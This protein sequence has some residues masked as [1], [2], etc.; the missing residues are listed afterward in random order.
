[1]K[2]KSRTKHLKKLGPKS[3]GRKHLV[4]S[5]HIYDVLNEKSKKKIGK[6]ICKKKLR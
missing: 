6:D 2:W 5:T 3:E 4:Y 1:M